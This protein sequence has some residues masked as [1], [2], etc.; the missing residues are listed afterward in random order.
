MPMVLD[1]FRPI[2]TPMTYKSYRKDLP[3]IAST[4][5]CQRKCRCKRAWF[6]VERIPRVLGAAAMILSGFLTIDQAS[7]FLTLQSR[8]GLRLH[9]SSG[10]SQMRP[11][12]ASWWLTNECERWVRRA[13]LNVNYDVSITHDFRSRHQRHRQWTGPRRSATYSTMMEANAP[14]DGRE[15]RQSGAENMGGSVGGVPG[16]SMFDENLNELVRIELEEVPVRVG[17]TTCNFNDSC[18]F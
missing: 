12:F 14:E 5:T 9:V 18:V 1:D 16:Y 17:Y 7:G 15:N 6:A 4:S 11:A 13:R 10:S 2:S 3:S 8:G